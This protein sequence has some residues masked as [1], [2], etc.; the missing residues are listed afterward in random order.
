MLS[1]QV[2]WHTP[3]APGAAGAP[4]PA[5]AGLRS[6]RAARH[7]VIARAPPRCAIRNELACSYS[8][9]CYDP[10]SEAI[11]PCKD[12]MYGVQIDGSN[13]V[14]NRSVEEKYRIL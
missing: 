5:P 11:K 2:W 14:V 6:R 9:D 3:G 1:A 10:N 7:P 8:I 13:T 12:E 4:A